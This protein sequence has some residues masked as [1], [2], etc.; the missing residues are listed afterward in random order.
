MKKIRARKL[1]YS[2]KIEP[3]KQ[4]YYQK[5]NRVLIYTQEY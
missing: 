3:V 4:M 2:E 5:N 1:L